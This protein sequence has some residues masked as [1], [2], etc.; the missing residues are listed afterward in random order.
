[1]EDKNYKIIDFCM[2]FNLA[3]IENKFFAMPNHENGKQI[4]MLLVP[5]GKEDFSKTFIGLYSEMTNMRIQ[6]Y[7]ELPWDV[8]G[9]KFTLIKF[10]EEN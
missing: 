8:K 9:V 5:K 4:I 7:E 6:K 10:E 1:M 3:N 2:E